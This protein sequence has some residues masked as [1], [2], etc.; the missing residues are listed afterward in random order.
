MGRFRWSV[1]LVGL[2][3]VGPLIWVL[4]RG[5]DFDPHYIESP[6]VG[7]NAPDFSLPSLDGDKT[8]QLA[9]LG[10][11]P[12]VVNFW[13]TW[14]IPCKQEHPMLVE[15]ARA[16]GDAVNFVGIVY[17]DEPANIHAW[18]NRNG[19]YAFPILIDQG[20][21]AAIAYGV[22]GVPESFVL[23]ASGLIVHKF[24]GPID[25]TQLQS[26]LGSL[27]QNRAATP[28]QIKGSD[29]A[30]VV[31]Q[32]SGQPVTGDELRAKTKSIAALLRCPTC[33]GMSAGESPSDAARAM[34][35]E[36]ERLVA[37]GYDQ[38]QILL[39]FEASYGEF[40]RLDPKSGGFNDA[41]WMLPVGFLLIGGA[42]AAWRMVGRRGPSP[43]AA[44][45]PVTAQTESAPDA[46]T[47]D[48]YLR[49]IREE[50]DS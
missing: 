5:F 30:A 44:T 21:S 34:R 19:G 17:Q 45:A 40:I 25:P 20:T 22:Y 49:R 50:L 28:G 24:T 10:G 38:E 48:P 7:R 12:T 4:R 37:Q 42:F 27:L 26:L 6:L 33:Q 46:P 11:K 2:L 13:A 23:D 18:L 14:C 36:V 47:E 15:A 41:V 3:L 35:G 9:D 16:Y 39:Y 8:V 31:G 1:L 43:A 32:P 29:V